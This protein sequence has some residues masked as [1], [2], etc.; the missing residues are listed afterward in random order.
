MQWDVLHYVAYSYGVSMTYTHLVVVI[1]RVNENPSLS[2][3]S[4]PCIRHCWLLL[5]EGL[6]RHVLGK[7]PY[8]VSGHNTKHL[9]S[10]LAWGTEL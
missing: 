4:R 5:L 6:Q 10:P 7:S 1:H 2:P 9:G 8:I 3:P